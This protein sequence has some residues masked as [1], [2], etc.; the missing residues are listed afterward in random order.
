[1]D[2]KSSLYSPVDI[3]VHPSLTIKD[4]KCQTEGKNPFGQVVDWF[5]EISGP[6]IVPDKIKFM[7]DRSN[8]GL[9][10]GS[11]CF[12]CGGV[13]FVA[14]NDERHFESR[15][16][17]NLKSMHYNPDGTLALTLLLVGYTQTGGI[18]YSGSHQW[19][20]LVLRK[21]PTKKRCFQRFGIAEAGFW[22]PQLGF[23]QFRRAKRTKS[24]TA[25]CSTSYDSNSEENTYFET[26]VVEEATE[27]MHS[28]PTRVRKGS[29]K[30]K[31]RHKKHVRPTVITTQHREQEER[32]LLL[33]L[34]LD[35][36]E[37]VEGYQAW[38]MDEDLEDKTSNNN[39]QLQSSHGENAGQKIFS[40]EH[41]SKQEHQQ[42]P[43]DESNDS[44]I[45]LE[46]S[47]GEPYSTSRDDDPDE[48]EQSPE[49]NH[50]KF[51]PRMK[52]D[53]IMNRFEKQ[54]VLDHWPLR[55]FRLV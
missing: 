22:I 18:R 42:K 11:F 21:S 24:M 10:I 52:S 13:L 30:K 55:T 6:A 53:S 15:D 37:R 14:H 25:Q 41:Y 19:Y 45:E 44:D 17:S 31:R 54:D 28:K 23:S 48:S 12:D 38:E 43:V 32:E 7:E 34:L 29:S 1:M 27:T 16:L 46:S 35:T 51:T 49:D 39:E 26:E 5:I 4:A 3:D 36:N 2:N 50:Q 33:G 20:A 40:K 47:S 9:S 8:Y